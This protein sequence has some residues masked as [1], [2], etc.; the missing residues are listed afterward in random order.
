MERLSP[1]PLVSFTAQDKPG[2]GIFILVIG[3]RGQESRGRAGEKRRG[4]VG[5]RVV[6]PE[7]AEV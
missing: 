4:E 6:K 7:Y 2:E 5:W 1:P 3:G